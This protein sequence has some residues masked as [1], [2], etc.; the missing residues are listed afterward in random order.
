MEDAFTTYHHH[1]S[2]VISPRHFSLVYI[3]GSRALSQEGGK[4][5]SRANF[6]FFFASSKLPSLISLSSCPEEQKKSCLCPCLLLI[7]FMHF[8]TAISTGICM[9][10]TLCS[11]SI[12][13]YVISFQTEF[14][15]KIYYFSRDGEY[16]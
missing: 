14:F 13:S 10:Q 9:L 5:S 1:V 11:R 16:S 3:L 12:M 7:L 6:Y 2:S 4:G 8:S 15:H